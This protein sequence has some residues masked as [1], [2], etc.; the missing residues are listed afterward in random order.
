MP[1]LKKIKNIFKKNKKT[2][3]S[4]TQTDEKDKQNVTV[5]INLG[6]EAY[7]DRQIDEILGYYFDTVVK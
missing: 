7:Y 6:E 1:Y 4:F 3:S 5:V 2:T